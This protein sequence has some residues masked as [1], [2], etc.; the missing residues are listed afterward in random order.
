MVD[1]LN[2]QLAMAWSCN[3]MPGQAMFA[4]QQLRAM[5][6]WELKHKFPSDNARRTIALAADNNILSVEEFV[7]RATRGNLFQELL[8]GGKDLSVF[9]TNK[10]VHT[11]QKVVW[12]Y[13]ES[14]IEPWD[15]KPNFSRNTSEQ[16]AT[17]I[18]KALPMWFLDI[19]QTTALEVL[20]T[21]PTGAE[22]YHYQSGSFIK[23]HTQGLP[24][25]NIS[26]KRLGVRL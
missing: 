26:P 20:T 15:P 6:W 16:I 2:R 25:L 13:Y 22:E 12:P 24:S 7:K 18:S 17:A 21:T 8:I 4:E 23:L 9:N 1:E 5:D 19:N 11:Y 10:Y 3:A 14:K